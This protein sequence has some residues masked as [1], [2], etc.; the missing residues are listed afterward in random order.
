MKSKIKPFLKWA[1]GKANLA[2]EIIAYFPPEFGCYFE[3]FLGA[4]AIALTLQA[5]RAFLSDADDELINCYWEL[6]YRCQ[7]TIA[8]C[9]RLERR[10]D[11]DFYYEVRQQDRYSTFAELTPTDK[12]AR[13][14][15]LNKT[16]F[17]GL[18]RKNSKGQFNVPIGDHKQ[19]QIIDGENA[20]LLRD[21]LDQNEVEVLAADF[22]WVESKARSCDLLYFDPPYWPASDTANFT[23]YT[24]DTFDVDEQ[25]RLRALIDRLSSR[26]CYCAL[27]N[28]DVPFIRELYSPKR[29][30]IKELSTRRNIGAKSQSRQ[31]VTELLI[32]NY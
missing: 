1:G 25:L 24:G 27:S 31:Q 29:Y 19:P 8:A 21:Y 5:P 20:F 2:E 7:T 22:Q 18:Y 32:L 26:G 14:I 10:H 4:G 30:R 13:T 15:Y 28:S 16:C 23:S 11:K 6:Q 17:N 3:P 9:D 12:A